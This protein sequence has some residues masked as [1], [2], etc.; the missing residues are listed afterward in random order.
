MNFTIYAY[1]N[2]VEL[3]TVLNA[4]A[5]LVG[6]SDFI[7]LM[8]TVALVVFI[9]LTL[10]ILAGKNKELDFGR[11]IIMVAFMNG[12]MLVPKV[13]VIIEDRTGTA[14]AQTVANVPLGFAALAG[15]VSHIGDW[16][17]RM[18]ETLF[19][20]PDDVQ[21]RQNGVM[22]GHKIVRERMMANTAN[23]V[24]ANNLL[25]FYR[26]CV[27]PDIATGYLSINAITSSQDIWA[28]LNGTLNPGIYVQISDY[29]APS[30]TYTESCPSAYTRIS[31]Q[32]NLDVEENLARMGRKM[33]PAMGAALAKSTLVGSLASTSNY[34]LGTAQSAQGIMRQA[35]I[36]N[37]ILDA[38]YQIPAQI[39]DSSQAQVKLAQIQGLRSFNTSNQAMAALAEETMP[40]LRNVVEILMYALFPLIVMLIVVWGHN[41]ITVIK[42]Y[43]GALLW[44]Q[45]WAPLYAILNFCMNVKTSSGLNSVTAGEGLA[46]KYYSYVGNAVASDQAVAGML[47]IAIP[48]IAYGIT[49]GVVNLASQI[50]ASAQGAGQ[51]GANLSQGNLSFG[52]SNVNATKQDMQ[53]LGS[54]ST[55]P[56]MRNGLASAQTGGEYGSV[57]SMGAGTQFAGSWGTAAGTDT[58][59]DGQMSYKEL[60]AFNGGASS[61]FGSGAGIGLNNSNSSS[62]YSG[63]DVTRGKG[64]QVSSGTTESAKLTQDQSAEF[65]RRMS[66]SMRSDQS[67]SEKHDTGV[68]VGQ[69]Q[70]DQ[71]GVSGSQALANSEGGSVTSGARVSAQGKNSGKAPDGQSRLS[72]SLHNMFSASVSGDVRTAQQYQEQA[73]REMRSMSQSDIDKTFSEVKSA[74]SNVA[75]G[76]NDEAVKSAAERISSAF[77]RTTSYDAKSVGSLMESASAGS[78]NESGVKNDASVRGD[79]SMELF[80][81][82]WGN[83][84]K[85]QGWDDSFN[86]E[87]AATFA[88]E[89]QN[90][91]TFRE[92][93][94]SD[95]RASQSGS[96]LMTSGG[97]APVTSAGEVRAQGVPSVANGVD[98]ARVTNEAAVADQR[99]HSARSGPNSG[100][101]DQSYSGR[102]G[103]I[104][105]GIAGAQGAMT[106]NQGISAATNEI[107]ND[108]Q[109]GVGTVAANTYF[110]GAGSASPEQYSQALTTAASSDKELASR[111]S[112]VGQAA[113]RGEAPSQADMAFIN[114]RAGKE[115]AK[116]E[117]QA[118]SLMYGIKNP[119]K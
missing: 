119:G 76:S 57:T 64:T 75:K 81:T 11:W 73:T 115:L 15:P 107:Y 72:E 66:D 47:S 68:K 7:G 102:V 50:A 33:Y 78:R 55:Q 21:L 18:N 90:N 46:V 19:G 49:Q 65:A 88:K 40:K 17:T 41:G 26:E 6:G 34:M 24:L 118:S 63:N 53:T 4:I 95:M 97:V 29:A 16:L 12:V 10:S 43:L 108:R 31:A 52:S 89:W 62:N 104:E 59:R 27:W 51:F 22:F 93:A 83:L 8:R 23:P 67:M 103:A 116:A 58:N 30:V 87:R 25:E 85:S 106:M 101:F 38:N 48:M 71:T 20:Q 82:A 32:I 109:K 92:Q 113:S 74:V 35:I 37:S 28:D 5:A 94:M 54:Y 56:T 2:T 60:D 70:T 39:G 99:P 111:L 44:V 45:L 91:A 36:G 105:G 112:S 86:N 9:S 79:N 114:E 80:R 42:L 13:N 1:W 84:A 14:A 69:Q 100:G 117:G 98:A 110:G 77:D 61:V 3:A 96:G